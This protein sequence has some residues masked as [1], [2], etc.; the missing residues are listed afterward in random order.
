MT[1]ENPFRAGALKATAQ[2]RRFPAIGLITALTACSLPLF[3]EIASP[4]RPDVDHPGLQ[5]RVKCHLEVATVEWH[6]GYPG[7]ITLSA[8]VRSDVV[9]AAYDGNNENIVVA[10]GATTESPLETMACYPDSFRIRV[11]RF[12]MAPPPPPAQTHA[13]AAPTPEKVAPPV[14]LIPKYVPPVN[15]VPDI[16]PEALAAV[17]TGISTEEV[18]R[19]LGPP[20]SKLAVP[21]PGDLVETFQYQVTNGKS[22]IVRFSN[23]LVTGIQTR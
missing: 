22:I 13:K 4:L 15:A 14:L 8:S 3:G 10:P 9:G 19:M 18:L 6:N 17:T 21:E 2:S 23:G 20:L 5:Y 16:S 12:V 7:Q 1:T 11:T